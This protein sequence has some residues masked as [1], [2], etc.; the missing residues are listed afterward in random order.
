MASKSGYVREFKKRINNNKK[1]V[2]VLQSGAL[3]RDNLVSTSKLDSSMTR[4]RNRC[5]VTGCS[6]GV[7]SKYRMGRIYLK[8]AARSGLLNGIKKS[9]W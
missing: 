8:T 1:R 6:R 9:S 7:I 2:N 5:L 3:Y 4:I